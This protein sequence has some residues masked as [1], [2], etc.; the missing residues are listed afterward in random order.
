MSNCVTYNHTLLRN[1]I[2]L[3]TTNS[4]QNVTTI[5]KQSKTTKTRQNWFVY[6]DFEI[7]EQLL[8]VFLLDLMRK[9]VCILKL[10]NLLNT[11]NN[12]RNFD[13][14]KIVVAYR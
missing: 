12:N 2:I 6:Q 9:N 3:L 14:L 10:I 8:M 4:I 5:N 13:A 7:I 1:I 11:L